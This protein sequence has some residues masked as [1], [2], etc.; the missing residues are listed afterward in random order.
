MTSTEPTPKPR[1]STPRLYLNWAKNDQLAVLKMLA[2][3]VYD[4]EHIRNADTLERRVDALCEPVLREVLGQPDVTLAL[5]KERTLAEQGAAIT[6][7]KL[8]QRAD[9]TER[10][11]ELN[12]FCDAVVRAYSAIGTNAVEANREAEQS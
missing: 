8:L 10:Y 3:V 7:T 5:I 2:W 11:C 6:A 4:R 12:Q 9:K 1:Y